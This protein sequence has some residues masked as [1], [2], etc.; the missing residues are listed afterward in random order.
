M[1]GVLQWVA[2][3]GVTAGEEAIWL[4]GASRGICKLESFRNAVSGPHVE[5]YYFY[6]DWPPNVLDL[7]FHR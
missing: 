3:L 4:P 7:P 2:S 1:I 6:A 5:I